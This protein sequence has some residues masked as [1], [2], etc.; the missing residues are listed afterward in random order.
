[1]IMQSRL[2]CLNNCLSA[3]PKNS[4]HSYKNHSACLCGQVW[5]K[6]FSLLWHHS[7]EIVY[8]KEKKQVAIA[9]AYSL[10]T[11]RKMPVFIWIK[12]NEQAKAA[13]GFTS[14]FILTA[15]WFAVSWQSLTKAFDWV[16]TGARKKRSSLLMLRFT[17]PFDEWVNM[18]SKLQC[19]SEKIYQSDEWRSNGAKKRALLRCLLLLVNILTID[20]SPSQRQKLTPTL[21]L[22]VAWLIAERNSISPQSLLSWCSNNAF[23]KNFNEFINHYRLNV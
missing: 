2:K 12:L 22:F 6:S 13:N 15:C 9:L 1:M 18:I 23:G 20:Y 19:I 17:D 14:R 10:K 4:C 21:I 3:N 7:K 16:E 11:I 5:W 8:W